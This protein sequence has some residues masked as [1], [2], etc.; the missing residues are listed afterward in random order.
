MKKIIIL[1]CMIGVIL[2]TTACNTSSSESESILDP[3][4]FAK[5]D[6]FTV[7][8]KADIYYIVYNTK[9]KVMYAVSGSNR[10]Y[11]N[12]TLLVNADGTPMT[13]E[14]E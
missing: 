10:N 12:F 11:G 6:M 2:S 3:A 4:N 8:D 1:I 7:I 9:T 13:Y 5:S 14:G